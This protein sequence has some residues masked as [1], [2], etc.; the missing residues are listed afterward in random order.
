MFK[1]SDYKFPVDGEESTAGK[2]PDLMCKG[3]SR[4]IGWGMYPEIG[5]FKK[6][7]PNMPYALIQQCLTCGKKSYWNASWDTIFSYWPFIIARPL[8]I[9]LEGIDGAGKTS[10]AKQLLKYL[11]DK[12]ILTHLFREPS[13]SSYGNLIRKHASKGE[14]IPLETELDL[15]LHDRHIDV[16]KNIKPA[17]AENRAVIMDRYYLSNACYQGAKGLDMQ[18]IIDRNRSF[19]EPDVTFIIDVPVKTAMPRIHQRGKADSF[20]TPAFLEKVRENYLMQEGPGIV[21]ID[22]QNPPE[23]VLEKITDILAAMPPK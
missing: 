3:E 4:A 14:T 19:P 18:E 10:I 23:V 22:G 2:C 9:A 20:E 1:Y 7:K 21:L 12:E 8:L 15:F 17:L 5:Y 16:E 13:N 11:W 6:L